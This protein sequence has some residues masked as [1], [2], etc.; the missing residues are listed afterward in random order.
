MTGSFTNGFAD[1]HVVRVTAAGGLA[2]AA[3]VAGDLSALDGME[4]LDV[5]FVLELTV[6]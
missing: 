6:A 2:P 1:A 4:L 5:M 3:P